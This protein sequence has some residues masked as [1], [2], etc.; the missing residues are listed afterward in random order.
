MG[1]STWPAANSIYEYSASGSLLGSYTGG[2][3]LNITDLTYE[4][5]PEPATL[6]LMA[7][8]LAGI[9]GVVRRKRSC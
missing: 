4:T 3:N 1:I 6:I 2:P 5:V 7:S 9:A 8:G